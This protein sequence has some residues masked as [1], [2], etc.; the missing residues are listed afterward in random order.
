MAVYTLLF[1]PPAI[2]VG[3]LYS[4]LIHDLDV[5][6]DKLSSLSKDWNGVSP[7]LSTAIPAMQS[8]GEAAL[9]YFRQ[10]QILF[11]I[12]AASSLLLS[13]V[14]FLASLDRHVEDSDSVVSS[15]SW[16]SLRI[17]IFLS[18]EKRSN[19]FESPSR[20]VKVPSFNL[21]RRI[22]S[23]KECGRYGSIPL[24]PT[25]RALANRFCARTKSPIDNLFHSFGQYNHCDLTRS[26]LV[27]NRY[28]TR[29][30]RSSKPSQSSSTTAVVFGRSF[31]FTFCRYVVASSDRS[32][33]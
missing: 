13:L 22:S 20:A 6:T 31:R 23:Y 19:Q 4:S 33:T 24:Y 14:C 2:V 15:R 12:F 1:V 29:E 25:E 18:F 32:C 9:E 21:L 27:D 28:R 3:K 16:R 26:Q 5:V 11:S 8:M 7:D 30:A 17:F 10:L